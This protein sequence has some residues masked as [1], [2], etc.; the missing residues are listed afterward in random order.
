MTRYD[1]W[2]PQ[3]HFPLC[4]LEYLLSIAISSVSIFLW[5]FVM[6]FIA[7][8][9]IQFSLKHGLHQGSKQVLECVI[10]FLCSLWLVGF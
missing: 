6:G 4:C 3:S 8:V 5:A 1:L 2:A 7:K 9:M 10:H